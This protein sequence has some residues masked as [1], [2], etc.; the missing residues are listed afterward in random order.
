MRTKELGHITIPIEHFDVG[1]KVPPAYITTVKGTDVVHVSAHL[2]VTTDTSCIGIVCSQKKEDVPVELETIAKIAQ[3]NALINLFEDYGVLA[4]GFIFPLYET[5]DNETS[6][7]DIISDVDTI[8]KFINNEVMRNIGSIICKQKNNALTS[9]TPQT[10][11]V[12]G[13]EHTTTSAIPK[14]QYKRKVPIKLMIINLTDGG[15]TEIMK[16]EKE[17]TASLITTYTYKYGDKAQEGPDEWRNIYGY[18]Y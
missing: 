13:Q 1:V 3:N 7:L 4:N 8:C 2:V 9:K 18:A 15:T 10:S 5:S 11:M 16:G 6:P 12:S 17:E 14:N